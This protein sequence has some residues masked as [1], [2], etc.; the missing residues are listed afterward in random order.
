MYINMEK[1]Q[2]QNYGYQLRYNEN[3]NTFPSCLINKGRIHSVI[4]E[5]LIVDSSDI[6]ICFRQHTHSSEN[7]LNLIEI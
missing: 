7:S 4:L 5:I 2:K 3:Y 6:K 1:D